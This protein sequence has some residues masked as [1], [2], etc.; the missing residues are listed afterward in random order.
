LKSATAR[1][2]EFEVEVAQFLRAAGFEVTNNARVARPRQTNLFAKSDDYELLIE[3]KNQKRKLDVNDIDALRSR[4]NRTPGDIVGAI[5]A[6]SG[7]TKGAI[8]AI[9]TDRSREVLAFVRGEIER[10]RS[11]RQ[12]LLALIERKRTELRVQGKAWFGQS[13]TTLEFVGVRLP[14]NSAEFF[15]KG[16]AQSCIETRSS[17]S[18]A[19]YAL[20]I[21]DPGWV[22]A[23][24]EGARLSIQLALNSVHDLRDI[25]GYLHQKFG[26]SSNAIFSIHQSES[27]WYGI[28]VKNFLDTVEGWQQRYAQ[29]RARRFH[30]SES[31]TYFDQF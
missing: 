28:G 29:S 11:G 5:F 16:A 27:C 9:E 30:H 19:S 24:G 2:R 3:A 4:L 15:A 14:S 23:G 31:F 13:G 21:P 20:Q 18:G 8:K 7:I 26:L 6:T 1:G 12:N 10:V 25:V 22:G 17:F